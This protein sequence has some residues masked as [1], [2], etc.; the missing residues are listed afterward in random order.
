MTQQTQQEEKLIDLLLKA[1]LP[2]HELYIPEKWCHYVVQGEDEQECDSEDY[3]EKCIEKAVK[4]FS[5]RYNTRRAKKL[6]QLKDLK[7]RG[8]VFTW[9]WN[10]EL[11]AK[12]LIYTPN[13]FSTRKLNRAIKDVEDKYP[14]NELFSYVCYQLDGYSDFQNCSNCGIIISS[15]ITADMQEIKHWE[16]QP[17]TSYII[18]DMDEYGAYEIY[19][20]VQFIHQAE[21]DVYKIGMDIIKRI[22]A[23]NELET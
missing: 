14:K 15:C 10:N 20:W 13:T 12:Y 19:E 18:A 1:L 21:E 11:H 16:G 23:I 8:Y 17:D 7:N 9:G 4:E 6:L 2:K 22:V 5:R 3:C